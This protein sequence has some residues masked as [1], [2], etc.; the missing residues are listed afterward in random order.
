MCI[1]MFISIFH[2]SYI[3]INAHIICIHINLCFFLHVYFYLHICVGY[4]H[5]YIYLSI[6]VNGELICTYVYVYVYRSIPSCVFLYRLINVSWVQKRYPL[7]GWFPCRGELWLDHCSGQHHCLWITD[8]SQIEGAIQVKLLG[9]ETHRSAQVFEACGYHQTEPSGNHVWCLARWVW[10]GWWS[11]WW[12]WWWWWGGWGWG[13]RDQTKKFSTLGS[14]NRWK[15]WATSVVSAAGWV[16][17]T[18]A[19]WKHYDTMEH[20]LFTVLDRWFWVI[21]QILKA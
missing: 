15:H 6:Y 11:W 8:V 2:N 16:A 18:S 1:S 20:G 13:G 5:I 19:G 3:Y 7:N 14:L 21:P 17:C 12:W 4:I 9:Q 10:V